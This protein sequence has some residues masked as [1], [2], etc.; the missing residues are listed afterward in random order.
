MGANATDGEDESMNLPT[1]ENENDGSDAA[2]AA[3]QKTLAEKEAAFDALQS[4]ANAL[5]K[6]VKTLKAES[7]GHRKAKQRLE[8]EVAELAETLATDRASSARQKKDSDML[9]E[10]LLAQI[11]HLEATVASLEAAAAQAPP[12]PEA[13]PVPPPL[14]KCETV[15][16]AVQSTFTI[17]GGRDTAD[18]EGP[19]GGAVEAPDVPPAR[20]TT[21]AGG[22]EWDDTSG[23][24]RG[25]DDGQ[26]AWCSWDRAVVRRSLAMSGH[27]PPLPLPALRDP[28]AAPPESRPRADAAG[29]AQPPDEEIAFL[30]TALMKQVELCALL[31]KQ[32]NDMQRELT[33]CQSQLELLV[34][35]ENEDGDKAMRL[36]HNI[37]VAKH[38]ATVAQLQS[39]LADATAQIATLQEML[40]LQRQVRFE[41]KQAPQQQSVSGLRTVTLSRDPGQSL[42]LMLFDDPEEGAFKCRGIRVAAVRVGSPAYESR[43]IFMGD[44]VVAVN[45]VWCLESSYRT[46]MNILRDAGDLVVLSLASAQDVDRSDLL[47]S[48]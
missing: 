13:E 31:K 26:S 2:M 46:V 29:A 7:K 6:D 36:R 19:G 38:D 21:T 43:Q 17:W 40:M 34:A 32:E 27:G 12:P 30:Q 35:L 45:D 15:D 5:K 44:A 37:M 28:A 22:H 20:G 9:H 4:Q 48:A 18:T 16:V 42:G 47:D 24:R 8:K 14:P 39:E 33:A 23:G 11:T 3:L 41:R 25:S 10:Q 1:N